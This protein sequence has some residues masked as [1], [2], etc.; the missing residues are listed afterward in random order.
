MKQYR[1]RRISP[2]FK[3]EAVKLMKKED[4]RICE[5]ARD[6]HISEST[7]RCWKRKVEEEGNNAFKDK[8]VPNKVYSV[9]FGSAEDA[10]FWY[11]LGQSKRLTVRAIKKLDLIIEKGSPL[12]TLV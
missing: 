1:K 8:D 4:V 10:L 7:L 9:L 11:N 3:N 6:M 5:L 2:E 12:T